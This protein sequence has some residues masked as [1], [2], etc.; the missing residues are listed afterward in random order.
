MTPPSERRLLFL[1]GAVQFVNILDFIMVMPLGPDFATGLGIPVS[2]LGWI[3]GSYTAAAAIAGLL[4]AAVLDR[5]DRR[6]ALGVAMLALAVGTAAGGFATGLSTLMAARMLA[7]AFGGP[8][9]SLSLAIIADHF[10]PERRGRAMGAVM[11]AFSAASV[12]GVPLGLELAR[13]GGW[14]LPFFAVAALSVVVT[15]LTY[16]WLPPQRSHLM[17]PS[18]RRRVRP[19]AAFLAD[20]SVVLALAGTALSTLGTFAIIPNISAYFQSN[21]GYP[22]DRLGLLYLFGGV[23]SFVAMRTGGAWVDRSGPAVVVLAGSVLVC[24]DLWLGFLTYPPLLSPLVIFVGFMLAN[25]LRNVAA[26]SLSSR[27]PRADERARFMSGQAAVQHFSAAIG[28]VL[29]SLLLSELPDGSLGGM[30]SVAALAL[31]TTL[32]LPWIALLL[33]RNVRRRELEELVPPAMPG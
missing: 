24:L 33:A 22:R 9:T 15:S 3:G 25:S 8:A 20:R 17:T 19:L 31:L 26:T 18:Q 7:G 2:H 16:L 1:L 13:I 21:L 5:F 11:G 28:A 14:R 6:Q 30:S 29:S 10:P 32:A 4:G 12:L 23:V 27:V